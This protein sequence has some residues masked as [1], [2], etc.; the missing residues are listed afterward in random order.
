MA[1]SVNFRYKDTVFRL[2]FSDK[3]RL[4]SLYNVLNK[5]SYTNPDELKVVTLENAIYMEVKND[6][7]FLIADSLHLYEHQSTRNPNMPLRFLQYIASAYQR[8]IDADKRNLYSRTLIKLPAPQFVVFCNGT[9]EIAD[10]EIMCL[11]AAFE[12]HKDKDT[13]PLL[14]NK[15]PKLELFVDV[16]NI[17][18]GHNSRVLDACDTL[19][20]YAEFVRRTRENRRTLPLDEAVKKAVNDCIHD[21]ILKE[22][23]Q[24]NKAEVVGM[25][26]FEF[27]RDEYESMIRAEQ[28][29]AEARCI[30][31]GRE[32]GAYNKAV[33]TAKKALGRNIPRDVIADITG[34]TVE[35]VAAL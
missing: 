8:L 6:I 20:G 9:Q 29:E 18:A 35:E 1:D 26:I 5:T 33:A 30:A 12:K 28:R 32:E 11:S 2:L 24:A 7:A 34:L 14:N 27:D 19:G 15:R 4:L 13:K 22:F 16:Y 25:S 10:Y 23:F 21:G 17:N 3:A 31:K